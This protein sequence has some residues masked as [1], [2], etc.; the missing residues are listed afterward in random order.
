M[1][2]DR[3]VDAQSFITLFLMCLVYIVLNRLMNWNSDF[4]DFFNILYRMESND[5]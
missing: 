3:D 4:V 2:K 5:N 1:Q